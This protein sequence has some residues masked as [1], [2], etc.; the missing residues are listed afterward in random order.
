MKFRVLVVCIGLLTLFFCCLVYASPQSE[1]KLWGW[2]DLHAHPA[3]HLGFGSD[4]FGEWGIFWGKPG[5]GLQNSFQTISSDLRPCSPDKHAGTDIDHVRH[6]TRIEIISSLN[7]ITGSCHGSSGYPDF[8]DWP[9]AE[10]VLHQQ[11]HITSIRRAY[12]GGLRLMVASIADNEVLSTLWTSIGYNLAGNPVPLPDPEFDIKAAKKQIKFIKKLVRANKSW[13]QIAYSAKEAREIVSANKMAIVLALELDQLTQQQLLELVDG[14]GIR[15]V[16]LVHLVNNIFGGAAI[17]NDEFN[18]LNAFYHGTR[19]RDDWNSIGS[20]GFFDIEYDSN[21]SFRLKRPRLLVAKGVDLLAGGAIVPEELDE[22]SYRS[23]GYSERRGGGHKNTQGLT[24]MGEKG[25]LALAR[26]GVLIDVAHM[27]ERTMDEAIELVKSISYPILNSHTG[28]RDHQERA[29]SERAM[30]R[31]VASA[32][33]QLGGVIG[34]GTEH[35]PKA[36]DPVATWL[37]YYLECLD[38]MKGRGVA[39]G[40]DMN[41][42]SPQISRAKQMINYPVRVA[43]RFGNYERPLLSQSTLGRRAFNLSDDGLAHYGMLPDFLEALSQLHLGTKAVQALFSSAED[44][45]RMWELA[46]ERMKLIE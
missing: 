3:S 37:G 29:E 21:L 2:A 8:L 22:D 20:D 24:S 17:Y 31:R 12:D 10:N 13:M 9:S 39:F 33:W 15:L 4:E 27:S 18:A 14:Y 36:S 32:I 19:D 11:M 7:R 38:L 16:T 42:L 40:T 25:I 5:I 41:G 1:V 44:F 23:L 35:L 34:L 43:W 28:L 26:R 45:V 30:T 6:R 46:E